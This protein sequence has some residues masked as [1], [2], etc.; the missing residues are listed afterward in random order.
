[1][2]GS[3]P[4]S[5]ESPRTAASFRLPRHPGP[6]HPVPLYRYW[7][8]YISDHFYT[9][10]WNELGWGAHG[11]D[12]EGIQACVYESQVPGSVPLY[13]Y[14][15]GGGGD[16]FYT[17]NWDELGPGNYGWVYEN[18]QYFVYP[19]QVSALA[20]GSDQARRGPP[21]G[22]PGGPGMAPCHPGLR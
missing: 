8:A 14:W 18:I 1:M 11:W 19:L 9:T 20:P 12:Y 21:E 5:D 15:S 22:P 16:H 4:T 13:R 6:A 10:N 7:N 2:T 17:T 3:P